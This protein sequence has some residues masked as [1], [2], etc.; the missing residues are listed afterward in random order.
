MGGEACHEG[1][2]SPSFMLIIAAGRPGPI[3]L[4]PRH[5]HATARVLEAGLNQVSGCSPAGNKTTI[6]GRFLMALAQRR[7]LSEQRRRRPAGAASDARTCSWVAD[8]SDTPVGAHLDLSLRWESN[9]SL[10][11]SPRAE[12]AAVLPEVLRAELWMSGHW[13]SACHQR[14][15][16]GH[17]G[18]LP[19]EHRAGGNALSR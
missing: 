18:V 1:K 7:V 11:S 9:A 16:P 14:S 10:G 5:S 19:G 3:P 8:T 4:R 15:D 13:D 17:S 12:R 2:K 6:R